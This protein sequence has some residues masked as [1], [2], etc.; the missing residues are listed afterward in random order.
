M[1]LLAAWVILCVMDGD[2]GTRLYHGHN[3]SA[4][5]GMLSQLAV[6]IPSG[7]LDMTLPNWHQTAAVFARTADGLD[8]TLVF[9]EL[10][11]LRNGHIMMNCLPDRWAKVLGKPLSPH[12]FSVWKTATLKAED[13]GGAFSYFFCLVVGIDVCFV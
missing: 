8:V 2:M 13:I 9:H 4:R 12:V 11:P 6:W 5:V 3:M 1:G 7:S 10:R